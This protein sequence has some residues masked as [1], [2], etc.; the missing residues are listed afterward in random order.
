MNKQTKELWDYLTEMGIATENELCLVTSINGTN[1]ESLES[2]LYCRTSYRSLEQI[3]DCEQEGD[4]MKD[5]I[6]IV[7]LYGLLEHLDGERHSNV[8]VP[9][10]YAQR[11]KLWLLRWVK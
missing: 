1:E 6:L 11:V 2:V 5:N 8:Y 7:G 10:K 9:Y 4:T 3:K